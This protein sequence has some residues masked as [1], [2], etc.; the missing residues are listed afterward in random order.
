[1]NMLHKTDRPGSGHKTYTVAMV[2]FI[3]SPFGLE[4]A[5]DYSYIRKIRHRSGSANEHTHKSCV[6]WGIANDRTYGSQK[7]TSKR[8][9]VQIEVPEISGSNLS[10]RWSTSSET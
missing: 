1:M 3:S 5:I 8:K 2:D 4:S 10:M 6:E 9:N 7:A